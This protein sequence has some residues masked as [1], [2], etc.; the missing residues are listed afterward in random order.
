M[1]FLVNGG[2]LGI[3]AWGIQAALFRLL[4]GDSA[5][6][7]GVATALTYMPLVILNFVIQRAWIFR[8]PGLFRRFVMAN[9]A[10]MVLV[11]ML[12]SALR[13]A[14]DQLLGQPWGDRGGFMA[15]ALLGSIPSFLLKRFWVFGGLESKVVYEPNRR[16]GD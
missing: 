8:R 4:G 9:V 6:A 7:Y 16:V 5:T 1:K 14:L 2:L 13:H 10:I 15:A 3:L 12:S 11:S